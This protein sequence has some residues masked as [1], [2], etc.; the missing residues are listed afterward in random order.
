MITQPKHFNKGL[1]PKPSWG[2]AIQ[3]NTPAPWSNKQL[4]WHFK[5][6]HERII[7]QCPLCQIAFSVPSILEKHIIIFHEGQK[8]TE[9]HDHETCDESFL[10]AAEAR[11]HIQKYH[12]LKRTRLGTI[13]GLYSN[14]NEALKVEENTNLQDSTKNKPDEHGRYDGQPSQGGINKTGRTSFTTNQ[15]TEL[16]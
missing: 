6:I 13:V 7:N 16:D 11:E 1:L 4:K 15:L 10:T 5:N 12:I 14:E 9:L 8:N 3:L 2:R